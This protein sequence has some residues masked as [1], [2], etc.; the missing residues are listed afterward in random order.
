MRQ[1]LVFLCVLCLLAGCGA[2]ATTIVRDTPPPADNH[3]PVQPT[4]EAE[5]KALEEAAANPERFE[6]KKLIPGSNWEILKPGWID[7]VGFG[8]SWVLVGVII[9]LLWLLTR[10]GS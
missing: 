5:E 8:G 3:T 1:Y 4:P 10:V 2:E 9:F 6:K 7:V